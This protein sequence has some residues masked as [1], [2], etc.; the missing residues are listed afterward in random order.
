MCER[1]FHLVL[2]YGKRL[3][4]ATYSIPPLG[5][6]GCSGWHFLAFTWAGSE[7][8]VKWDDRPLRHF[9]HP[10][11]LQQSDFPATHF[12]I[13]SSSLWKYLLDDVIIYRRRLSFE[14]LEQIR[15]AP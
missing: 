8:S 6:I 9:S 11:P 14:E 13:G 2:L 7:F 5:K 4:S 12:S 3:P 10:L 15:L 1:P